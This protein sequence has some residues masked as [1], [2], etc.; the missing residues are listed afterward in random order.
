MK[1]SKHVS[2][3]NANRLIL[4]GIKAATKT[5]QKIRLALMKDLKQIFIFGMYTK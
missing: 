3:P 1:V 5:Y 4:R 2:M